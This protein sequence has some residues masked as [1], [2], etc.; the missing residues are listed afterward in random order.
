MIQVITCTLCLTHDCTLRCKY[1][2][3]GR[4]YRHAM[5]R[6][7]AQKAIDISLAEAKRVGRGLDL[8]FFGGEPLL[9]W[10]LLQWCFEYLESHEEGLI[11]QP[12][13]GIT[14]NG[15]LL[16]PERLEWMAERDF[17][18]GISIDGSP[19]MH[20]TNRC[21]AD[22]QGSHE[23]VAR[24]VALLDK[25]P[26]IRTKAI[27]VVTPNN[28]QYLAEGVEW[29]AAHFHKEIGLNIDYWSNWNDEQFDTLSEQYNLVAA[30]VLQSYREG[31]PIK[32][33]N[34]EHKI[35]SH[36]QSSESHTDC[37]K[38]TIGEREIGVSVDGNFFPCSRLVGVGDEPELNF[39]NVKDGI[40]RARQEWIIANRG[41]TTPACKLCELR[42]RCLNSC[43]CTNHAASGFIN[44]VSPF[45]CCSEKLFIE[46]A[47]SL[48]EIL[49]AEQNPHFLERFYHEHSVGY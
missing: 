37:V 25:H 41:N 27:C 20:N 1:C 32:L 24:A 23:A 29:L 13:Y 19:T 45:L 18:I 33:S 40:N 17:L 12:R 9:E 28:V 8:S 4:K 47:D 21:Y 10:E 26:T 39:G 6:E 22:G 14:T 38:C 48:A 15:T 43:G 36:I 2:Y 35:L 49:Y 31:T 30:R 16:T 34:I 5:T 44:Q 3:A 46:T 42:A 7:T 11:V